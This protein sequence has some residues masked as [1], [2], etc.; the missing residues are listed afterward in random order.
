MAGKMYGKDG[1]GKVRTAFEKVRQ[2]IASDIVDVAT[3]GKAGVRYLKKKYV[4][5]NDMKRLQDEFKAGKAKREKK[6]TE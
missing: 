1:S 3:E 5:N 2:N 4:N 6:Y